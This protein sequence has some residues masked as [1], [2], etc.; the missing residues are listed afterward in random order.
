MSLQSTIKFCKVHFH[1]FNEFLYE[2]LNILSM[3]KYLA[4]TH[5]KNGFIIS[6]NFLKV[7]GIAMLYYLLLLIVLVKVI[8]YKQCLE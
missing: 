8:N 7:I 2:V 5:K 1:S 3:Q 4:A 6:M